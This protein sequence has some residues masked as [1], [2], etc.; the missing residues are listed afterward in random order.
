MIPKTFLQWIRSLLTGGA[1]GD[2]GGD[3]DG[4]HSP[5]AHRIVRKDGPIWWA[6]TIEEVLKSWSRDPGEVAAV[7]RKVR[8]YLK[9]MADQEDIERDPDENEAL[10]VFEKTWK[11]LRQELVV[12]TA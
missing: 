9:L 8:H 4:R 10:A 1:V 5:D 12:N 6:P 2:G 7:D 3:W 11:V